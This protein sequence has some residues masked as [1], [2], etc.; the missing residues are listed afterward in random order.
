MMNICGSNFIPILITLLCCGALFMYFNLRLNEIKTTIEKQNRVLTAFIT[1]VQQDIRD[2]GS[3]GG[4]CPMPNHAAGL[5]TPEALAA[6][7]KIESEKIIVS[8]DE[9]DCESDSDDSSESESDSDYDEGESENVV[10]NIKIVNLPDL[11]LGDEDLVKPIPIAFEVLSFAPIEI[12]AI[13]ESASAN[14]SS[15]TE[16][17]DEP[18]NLADTAS[19]EQMKVDELRKVVS[20]KN[21]ASKE[22]VKKLKKPELLVLLKK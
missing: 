5:A 16:I 8:D 14:E 17:I 11:S 7:K 2:S 12:T 15:I 13:D 3:S 6:A 9:D 10:K 18:S 4:G 19:F 21:L 20:D 1:N 22:E